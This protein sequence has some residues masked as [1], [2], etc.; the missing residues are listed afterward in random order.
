MVFAIHW[1][2]SA[3]DLHVFPIPIPPPASLPIPSLW[4]FPVHQPWTLVSCIQP[5]LAICFTLDHIYVSML[6]L[7]ICE[8][9]WLFV[10][11]MCFVSDS[12]S[13][14]HLDSSAGS[15]VFS[16]FTDLSR[17]IGCRSLN[18]IH[19]HVLG[20]YCFVFIVT[21]MFKVTMINMFSKPLQNYIWEKILIQVFLVYNVWIVLCF[22][23]ITIMDSMWKKTATIHYCV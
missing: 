13:S 18:S 21:N 4:V 5:G 11:Q 12:S 19:I 10:K 2:E 22:K 7:N 14:P 3:M 9:Y 16:S 8:E 6:F 15:A 17:I 1:H 20:V 23:H